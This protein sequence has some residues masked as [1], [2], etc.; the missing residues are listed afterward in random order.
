MTS[1]LTSVQYNL[2]IKKKA[3][4]IYITHC[5][6]FISET[7]TLWASTI[8]LSCSECAFCIR[9]IS[10][11]IPSRANRINSSLSVTLSSCLRIFSTVSLYILSNGCEKLE[12][13]LE[14]RVRPGLSSELGRVI[15]SVELLTKS[16]RLEK[17][18]KKNCYFVNFYFSS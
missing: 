10:C 2:K 6:F 8:C 5:F 1:F 11:C 13:L 3:E 9:S 4:T 7:C 17:Q 18:E 12:T 16:C 14:L 15:F